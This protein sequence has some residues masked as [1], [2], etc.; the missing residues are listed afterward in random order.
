MQKWTYVV[1]S[2]K[3]IVRYRPIV[4]HCSWTSHSANEPRI[5]A[6]DI[7]RHHVLLIMTTT[8]KITRVTAAAA[9]INNDTFLILMT[10]H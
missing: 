2:L 6:Q 8:K 5:L 9:A 10:S 1:G 3:K 4:L 7:R